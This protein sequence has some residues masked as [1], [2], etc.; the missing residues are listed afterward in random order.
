VAGDSN[1]PGG[2]GSGQE[3]VA[4]DLLA[5]P[6]LG[7]GFSTL[8]A[9]IG[10][11]Q[12]AGEFPT[13]PDSFQ[14]AN[15]GGTDG[16]IVKFAILADLA[17][18][19][20]DGLTSA[21]PGT[22]I[23]YTIRVSNNDRLID[24]AGAQVQD[25]FSTQFTSVNWTAT[26]TAGS[27]VS[28]PSGSG[29]IDVTVDLLAGGS[30]TFTVTAAIS[31]TAT[32]TITNTATVTPP[33]NL[34]DPDLTN[35]SA[36]DRDPLIPEADLAVT[37]VDDVDPILPG[38]TLTYTITVTNQGPSAAA[39]VSLSDPLPAET[40][41]LSVT[42]PAGWTVAAPAEGST[43]TLVA[44]IASLAPGASATFTVTVQ[45][46]GA[47][48]ASSITNTA[49]VSSST[50]DPDL[51]N[52]SATEITALVPSSTPV[53][54]LV[55]PTVEFPGSETTERFIIFFELPPLIAPPVVLPTNFTSV[56]AYEAFGRHSGGVSGSGTIMGQVFED[57]NGNGI[58]DSNE[59]GLDERVVFAD[60]NRNGRYDDGEPYAFT[61]QNGEYYISGLGPDTYDVRSV[62]PPRLFQLTLPE[63]GEYQV[64]VTLVQGFIDGVNFGMRPLRP[65]RPVGTPTP[66]NGTTSDSPKPEPAP[67]NKS[68]SP[69]AA[70]AKPDVPPPEEEEQIRDDL[71]IDLG[72]Q[73][74]ESGAMLP[75]LLPLHPE[76]RDAIAVDPGAGDD[77]EE[78]AP[79]VCLASLAMAGL[80]AGA[81]TWAS[82]RQHELDEEL[83]PLPS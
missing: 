83:D 25:L 32:G 24:V 67:S 5:A 57:S 10:L 46:D 54:L 62:L 51:A 30:V 2:E 16:F 44:T 7:D 28:A 63:N 15:A 20:D 70:P 6:S 31:P 41:F 59:V 78:S 56:F 76:L 11:L 36:T 34:I 43:G 72:E 47:T 3:I 58:L 33:P 14:P 13:T 60:N 74:P 22:T 38:G 4:R 81:W 55:P 39:N 8:D 18:T 79:D 48:T 49:T 75:T 73:R 40:V 42:A 61:N 65:R 80:I 69:P 1:S 82:A 23:V 27:S 71:F 12:V 26:P 45:V 19:K 29:D 37:K 35:N 52:N 17:I 53:L 77:A 9:L 21:V 66:T 50:D 64:T 68:D